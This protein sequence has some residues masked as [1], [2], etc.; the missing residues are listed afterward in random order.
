MLCDKPLPSPAATPEDSTNS[1]KISNSSSTSS[2]SSTPSS[3]KPAANRS[4]A[5]S[6]LRNLNATNEQLVEGSGTV[7]CVANVG[8]V[9]AD[10][11][12]TVKEG[13]TVSASW[14]AI[15]DGHN[16]VDGP[17]QGGPLTTTTAKTN[18]NGIAVFTSPPL[19]VDSSDGCNITVLP[20]S[21]G[22]YVLDLLLSNLSGSNLT[23]R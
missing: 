7:I 3:P 10:W 4:V 8:M 6:A 12:D 20:P 22:V 17:G 13:L 21:D 16:E 23:W 11:S 9:S 5:E 1:S 19:N 14:Y 15:V 2:S 18:A